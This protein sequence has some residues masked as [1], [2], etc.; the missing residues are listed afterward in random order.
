MY[1]GSRNLLQSELQEKWVRLWILELSILTSTLL[2]LLLQL[3]D[4]YLFKQLI[5][6][7]LLQ[8]LAWLEACESKNEKRLR[9]DRSFCFSRYSPLAFSMVRL[10][11]KAWNSLASSLTRHHPS[12]WH[13][14]I[15]GASREW[16][17]LPGIGPERVWVPAD[18]KE[19]Q[20]ACSRHTIR[21]YICKPLIICFD[22]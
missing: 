11:P 6:P 13:L 1:G 15:T 22:L 19:W 20:A 17:T 21:T 12:G 3:I 8:A 4:M 7:I 5:W 2:S 18:D 16:V 10:Q 14:S 9:Q